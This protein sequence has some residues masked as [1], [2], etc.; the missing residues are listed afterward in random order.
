VNQVHEKKYHCESRTAGFHGSVVI[1]SVRM[2]RQKFHQ[3]I[4]H[5]YDTRYHGGDFIPF[6]SARHPVD[7]VF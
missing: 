6:D 5:R 3:I 1:L 2:A 7:R 4:P